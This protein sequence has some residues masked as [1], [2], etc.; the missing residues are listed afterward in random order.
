[1]LR[2]YAQRLNKDIADLF[3]HNFECSSS[4]LS[5]L[6]TADSMHA[7]GCVVL[8]VKI[9]E[10]PYKGGCFLFGLNIPS[11]YPFKAV[12]VYAKQPIWHPNVDISSGR[13]SLP[14]DWA[15][16]VTLVSLALAVQVLHIAILFLCVKL[17]P[18]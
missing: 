1:M 14:L 4:T 18:G 2:L 11:T 5:V 8:R 16:V 13:V 7:D 17:C 10:G 15:P 9:F 3:S 6:Q 12:E